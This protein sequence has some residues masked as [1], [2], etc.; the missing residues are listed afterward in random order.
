MC[1]S[2]ERIISAPD[3]FN[4]VV[5]TADLEVHYGDGAS[6]QK[7]TWPIEPFSC[8]RS[9]DVLANLRSDRVGQMLRF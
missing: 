6:S 3:K 9:R 8:I 5:K 2:K 1:E 4:G 7:A